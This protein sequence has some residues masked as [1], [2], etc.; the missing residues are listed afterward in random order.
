MPALKIAQPPHPQSQPVEQAAPDA[1]PFRLASES[2]QPVASPAAA[3]QAE[4]ARELQRPQRKTRLDPFWPLAILFS[5][6]CW[7]GLISFCI[8]AVHGYM[9]G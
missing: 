4:L 9:H 2:D 3:L 6:T 5:L 7:W 8:A 1:A